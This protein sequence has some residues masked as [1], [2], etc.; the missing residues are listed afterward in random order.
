M[1]NATTEMRARRDEQAFQAGAGQRPVTAPK[2]E[3][4]EVL[5]RICGAAKKALA[6]LGTFPVYFYACVIRP[7]LPNSCN[8]YPTC[9]AYTIQSIKRFGIIKGWRLGI[10]R[11]MRCNPFNKKGHGYDPVPFRYAGGAKW[12]I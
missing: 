12:V 4:N 1:A 7:L 3:F 2:A 9:S 10:W 11:I 5:R 6:F 8:F